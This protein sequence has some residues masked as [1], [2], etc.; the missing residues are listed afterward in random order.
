[1]HP[2]DR[3]VR[4]R[5]AWAAAIALAVCAPLAL[6]ACGDDDEE[7]SDAETEATAL[8]LTV[9]DGAGKGA[10]GEFTLPDSIEPGVNEITLTNDGEAP[11]SGQLLRTEGDYDEQEV[12]EALGAAMEGKPFP[13]WF[14][15][16]GGVGTVQPGESVTV[17][18]ALEP[19]STFWLVDDES[20][21]PALEELGTT[22]SGE[23]GEI[24]PTDNVVSASDYQFEADTLTSGEPVTLEND[25]EQPHHMIAQPFVGDATIEDV[26]QFL[27]T[28]KGKPPVDFESQQATAVLEG[29]TSQVSGA[30]LEPGRYALLCF[31]SDREGGPPHV[32]LGMIGEVE[33]E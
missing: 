30:E 32:E 11:H 13:E 5:K 12:L 28:E 6:A 1:M 14:F 19:D 27:K 2:V 3:T 10:P 26:E 22:G 4:G 17:T 21:E 23:T 31:I 20:R 25:G 29:G 9:T 33:V 7:S 15:A 24:E 8:D 16:G 18:Q